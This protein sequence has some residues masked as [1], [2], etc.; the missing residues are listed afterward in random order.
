MKAAL[1][2]GANRGLGKGFVEY[3]LNEEYQVFATMR[4]TDDFNDETISSNKNLRLVQLDITDDN[5]IAQCFNIVSNHTDHLDFLINNAGVNKRTVS[6][7]QNKVSNLL[8][9]DREL[10]LKMFNINAVSPLIVTKAF[11]K[12]LNQQNCFVINISS[13]KASINDEFENQTANYGYRA[14]KVALNM[15][16]FCSITDL[17]INIKTFSVDPGDV[18][19]DMNPEGD[20]LPIEQA[21]K[22][23]D[24]ANNWKKDFNGRFLRYNGIFYP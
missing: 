12:L 10:L 24:I 7:D 20:Y 21:T 19:T 16:T 23:I 9:L 15:F 17:P 14:S 11:L 8:E 22:I 5:S 4:N 18:K 13:S 1:I 6:S 2:T 3:F